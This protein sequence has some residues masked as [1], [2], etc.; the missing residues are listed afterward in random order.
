M[1]VAQRMAGFSPAEAN[2]LR[3]A[4]GRADTAERL[5]LQVGQFVEGCRANGVTDAVIN[6][7]WQMISSFAGYSFAK[8]HSASYAMVS[9]QCAWLKAHHPAVFL[10]RV[11]A[12]EGG[13]Y[14]RSAYVEEARRLGLKI[15]PPCVQVGQWATVAEH[16]A[17]R[18]GLH[19]ISGLAQATATVIR[20]EQPFA[21]VRD[22]LQRAACA[23]D[24][25]SA[26]LDAGALDGLLA[27][28]TAA[29][30]A[31]TVAIASG[32]RQGGRAR[33][34]GCVGQLTIAVEV[35]VDP[36]PPSL[37]PIVPAVLAQR[38]WQRLGALP[39]AHPLT[40]WTFRRRPRLR[41]SE[42]LHLLPGTYVA[43]IAMVITRK[44]VNAV[45]DEPA[46]LR[47]ADMAFVTVEDET[48]VVETTWFPETFK[49]Y[50]VLLERGEPLLLSGTV[51]HSWEVA[52]VAVRHAALCLRV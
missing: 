26:L 29:Q 20:R 4:L 50:A 51:E 38:R 45:Y 11:I 12:N 40:L 35:A 42:V 23:S 27:R 2:R 36:L 14:R 41:A 3:K 22:L 25:L 16:G 47:T 31:W 15:L 32:E 21:G 48:A 17:I 18:L 8:A 46:G 13:F 30:R 44:T 5:A 34:G 33:R 28:C 52:S 10:A 37:P 24:E 7:V 6:L 49:R 43:F 39:E 1:L 19:C 9:M